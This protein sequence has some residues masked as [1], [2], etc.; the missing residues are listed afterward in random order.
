MATA[1]V[2]PSGQYPP[3]PVVRY[4]TA[5]DL[6]AMPDHLPSGPVD[7]ELHQ[8]RLVP[9]SPPGWR[10]SNLQARISGA[11]QVQGEDK[12]YGEAGSEG[13]VILSKNPDTVVGP[14][15]LFITKRSLPVRLTPEGYLETIPELIVEIRSKNDSLAEFNRKAAD[16]LQA[17]VQMVWMIDP[18][19]KTVTEYRPGAAARKLS[20]AD[21]LHCDDIIPGFALSLAEFF[22]E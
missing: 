5:A 10:H 8:G 20:V 17:G 12:G 16:Y 22:R 21:T 19:S 18:Q 1:S 6:A 3:A 4:F 15:A 14:D 7:F 13:G 9:M 11:L 2:D